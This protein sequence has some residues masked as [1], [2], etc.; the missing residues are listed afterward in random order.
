MERPTPQSIPY[1]LRLA[2][3][4]FVEEKEL[5][6]PCRNLQ[7]PL[8]KA[9]LNG[10]VNECAALAS[11]VE[12]LNSGDLLGDSPLH[13]AVRWI[14]SKG[15]E[16]MNVLTSCGADVNIKNKWGQTPLHY[17]VFLESPN[18][19]GFLLDQ[20]SIDVNAAD[21]NWYTPLHCCFRLG[22]Y[23]NIENRYFLKENSTLVEIVDKL[24]PAGANIKAQTKYG[25]SI[26]HLIAK[27]DDNTPL[28]KHIFVNY[29]TSDL[30]LHLQNLKGENFLHVYMIIEIYEK[31]ID[32][33][34]F[35]ASNFSDITVKILLNCPDLVGR[36]PWAYMIDTSNINKKSLRRLHDLH[37]NLTTSD[38]LGNTAVHRLAGVSTIYNDILEFLLFANVDVKAKNVYDESAASVFFLEHVFDS[39]FRYGSDLNTQDRWGRTP[40]MSLLKHR[41]IP[42]LIRKVITKG[43]V[44]VDARDANGTTPLH[45][46]AYHNFEEQVE[47]LL[48]FQAD[49]FAVDSLGDKPMDTARRHCSYRC[50]KQLAYTEKTEVLYTRTNSFEDLLLHLPKSICSSKIKTKESIKN[51][52]HLDCERIDFCEFLLNE[53]YKK[54]P[55]N[56]KEIKQISE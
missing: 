42:E 11:N 30:D 20:Q 51:S 10:D 43:K 48:E 28:L 14:N 1:F 9:M 40:L 21:I 34:E 2:T 53:F 12:Y 4:G 5:E 37:A 17:A 27:R 44:D 45:L 50:F 49:A 25:D 31:V 38:N 26:L 36:A 16:L 23:S 19:V 6:Q 18:N 8:H 55:E 35:I 32:T 33:M 22:A 56:A 41:P 46:A 39:L 24:V 3:K 29:A 7:T 15:V 52:L 13:L 47:L 54:S